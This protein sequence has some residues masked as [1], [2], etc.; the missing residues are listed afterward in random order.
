MYINTKKN[1]I[2]KEFQLK[3]KKN[4]TTMN[5]WSVVIYM[6]IYIFFKYEY[7]S[8]YIKSKDTFL[9]ILKFICERGKKPPALKNTYF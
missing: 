6:Y 5:D 9:Y 8:V 1:T 7:L 3:K 4:R 2:P